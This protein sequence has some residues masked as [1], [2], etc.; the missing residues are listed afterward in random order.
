MYNNN[1][2]N[3]KETEKQKRKNFLMSIINELKNFFCAVL[4]F[5][6]ES[7][8]LAGVWCDVY[9]KDLATVPP[10]SHRLRSLDHLTEAML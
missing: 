5:L 10:L 8:Q 9:I 4:M 3:K 1:N 7:H 2:N 6:E